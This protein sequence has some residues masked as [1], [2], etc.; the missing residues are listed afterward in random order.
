M[1][2]NTNNSVSIELR[3]D[4]PKKKEVWQV[5]SPE[6]LHEYVSAA[7]STVADTTGA[8]WNMDILLTNRGETTEHFRVQVRGGGSNPSTIDFEDFAVEP[9][10]TGIRVTKANGPAWLTRWVSIVTTSLNLVPTMR[11]YI[12]VD[13][14]V[15]PPLSEYIFGPGD[16]AVFPIRLLPERPLTQVVTRAQI[17]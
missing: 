8:N 10:R 16:F 14:G 13:Q 9:L 11:F 7:V 2:L 17:A 6:Y 15:H 4:A 3:G 5:E 1:R 12:D